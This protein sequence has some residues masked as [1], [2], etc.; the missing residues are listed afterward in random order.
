M[1]APTVRVE[2]RDETLSSQALS[3]SLGA[4]KPVGHLMIGLPTQAAVDVL[5][6]ELLQAGWP[7]SELLTVK[8]QDTVADLETMVAHAGAMAGFGY[9]I[10]LL[11]RYLA[12]SRE[13]QC[14][15]LVKVDGAEHA[16]E[17]AEFARRNGAQLA[18]WYRTMTVEELI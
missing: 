13:G 16:Q 2:A 4:F 18:V 12:L 8:P 7:R 9:E 17:A 5:V 3:T 1:N 6:S 11:R 14:W 10:T 15:L